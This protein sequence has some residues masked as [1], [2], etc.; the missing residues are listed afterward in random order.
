MK[1]PENKFVVITRRTRLDELVV[2]FNTLAQAKFY[3]EHLGADFTDYQKEDKVYKEAL[4]TTESILGK[5]RRVQF[6]DRTFLPNYLFSESDIV[7]ALGQDGL[8]ANALKYLSG[9]PL[10]GVNPDLERWEGVLLP[11]SIFDLDGIIPQ[12]LKMKRPLNEVTM[13]Q[14]KLNTGERLR[15]VNDLFI[16]PKSHTS[17]RYALSIGNRSENQSSSGI[18]VSTGLGSTGWL[19]SILAGASGIISS[20]GKDKDDQARSIVAPWNADYLYYSVREPWPSRV[21]GAGLTFGKITTSMPLKITSQMPENGVIFS[22]GIENDFI[23]FNSGT[24][25]IVT[26]SEQKGYLVA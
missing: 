22:D 8:V 23:Q 6:V 24:T 2:R 25:A 3:I 7:I 10:V 1:T 14:V 4:K 13:A 15:A 20:I 16:G 5:Y 17:A 21:S 11:F 9:Q 12:I 19:K 26:L 18:I